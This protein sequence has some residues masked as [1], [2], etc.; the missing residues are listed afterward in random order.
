V[1][2][3]EIGVMVGPCLDR[4]IPDEATFIKEIA[5]WSSSATQRRF[6]PQ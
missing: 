4:R 2:E 6:T 3:R 1:V 5:A